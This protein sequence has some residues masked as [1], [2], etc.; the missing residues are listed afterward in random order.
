[1][2]GIGWIAILVG[3]ICSASGCIKLGPEYRTPEL[4][5]DVPQS[6]QYA[7]V[8]AASR[9][10]EDQWWRIFGNPEI[11]RL[12]EEVLAN[13]LDLRLAAARIL[14]LRTRVI[15]ARAQRFPQVDAQAEV[16]RRQT[17]GIENEVGPTVTLYRLSVPAFF[18]LDLWA[19]L[20]QSEESVWADLL[21]A[22]ENRTALAQSLAAEAIILY[23]EIEAFE[24]RIQIIEQ[25]ILTFRDS[26]SVV[27]RRYDR[28]LVSSLD[29]RQARRILAEAEAVLPELLRGLGVS[30]QNLSVL[31]GRYPQT[32]P[33]RRQPE[34]YFQELPPV[35][36]GLPSS[37]LRRRPDVRAAEARLQS[38]NALIGVAKAERFPNITLTGNLAYVGEQISGFFGKENQSWDLI[39]GLFYPVFNAEALKARQ[40]GAEARYQQ[41]VADY[42]NTVLRAFAEVE[43]ALL[44]REMELKRRDRVLNFLNEAQATQKAAENR[45]L[46]GLSDYLSVL[47]AQQT[48][49]QA[50]ADLV[51]V[52]LAILSNRVNL[53]R[54]LGGS[55]AQPDPVREDEGFRFVD[56]T[57]SF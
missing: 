44:T 17:I 10:L 41:G 31:L 23:L 49:V 27:E 57:D 43:S 4:S 42:I 2:K 30:Q 14:E 40:R 22:E 46:R 6:F 5:F 56:F 18:E 11:D 13:N 39:G 25:S 1:M 19:R 28:G 33:S 52:D 9:Q 34:N 20:Q 53:H 12:V 21:Q 15:Q 55:W 16:I 8:T 37:L 45:Y 32:R 7:P 26:L 35:P 51:Q 54:A 48:F 47:D 36:P 3:G 29:V 50:Q 38:L 24:R